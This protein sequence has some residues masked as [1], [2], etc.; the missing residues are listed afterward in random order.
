VR[1]REAFA[2]FR[3]QREFHV[4]VIGRRR[5]WFLLS[6]ALLLLSLG[7]LFVRQLNL[8]IDFRGGA[9]LQYE[10][11]TGVT[12]DDVRE[13]MARFD[14]EDAV[15][16]L[17]GGGEEIDIRTESLG[18]DRAALIG[19][20]ARQAGVEPSDISVEDIGPR[21]GQQISAKALQGLLIFLAVVSLYITLRFEWKMAVGA[22]AALL[23][24]LTITAG[25]YALVG[26]EVTPETVIAILTI[27][28][29]SLYDTVV[30]FDKIKENAESQALVARE[31]YSGAV[32]LSLNQVMMRS[33][34]TSLATLF[35][36]G[37]LLLFGG[38]TLKDFAFAL[39]IG[40]IVGAYSSIFVAAPVVAILKEREPR[41]A[42]L[43]E[44]AVQRGAR[45]ALRA[46][47]SRDGG[48]E[49]EELEAV[50]APVSSSGRSPAGTR[51]GGA[52][53]KAPGKKKPRSKKKRR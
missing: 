43:R 20:L 50:G 36:I 47:P 12:A 46:V 4:D 25:F 11:R 35:P 53:R 17:V 37:T 32:N 1:L 10:N 7:G 2:L 42:R 5:V 19:A 39:F 22:L 34:N 27:L 23:H 29:Y 3:G 49:P 16:Q 9:I 24:D 40:V 18:E 38:E 33:F 31:T 30:I 15:V 8:G 51:P 21:W 26:R 44:R 52:R 28:G 41:M 6:G 45:P 48:E 14:R 13:T